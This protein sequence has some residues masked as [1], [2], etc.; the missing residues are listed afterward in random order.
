M[1]I[2]LALTLLA[3][4]AVATALLGAAALVGI[5]PATVL[6]ECAFLAPECP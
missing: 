5:V 6:L 1:R 2:Y 4:T 3:A